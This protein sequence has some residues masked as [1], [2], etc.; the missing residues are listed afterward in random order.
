MRNRDWFQVYCTIVPNCLGDLRDEMRNS[1]LMNCPIVP[2]CLGD[3]RDE[4]RNSLLIILV[5][6]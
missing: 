1:L 4:L 5:D 6:S 2:N 3:L